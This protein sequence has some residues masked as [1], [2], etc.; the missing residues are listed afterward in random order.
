MVFCLFVRYFLSDSTQNGVYRNIVKVSTFWG[1]T[2]FSKSSKNIS[3][4]N[5]RFMYQANICFLTVN[6]DSQWFLPQF[7]VT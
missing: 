2:N 1:N 5:D 6:L 3:G 7:D 4:T